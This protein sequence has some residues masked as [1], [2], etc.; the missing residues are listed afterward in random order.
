MITDV[1]I[2]YNND[3]QKREI[4]EVVLK[5]S[6]FF[7]FI[8][9]RTYQGKKDARVLKSNWGAKQSPFILCTEGAIPKKCFYSETGEDVIKSLINYLNG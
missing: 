1:F 6:P 3:E 9:D 7:H 8:D 4:E 2:V 5:T